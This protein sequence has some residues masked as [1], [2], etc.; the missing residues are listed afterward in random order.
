MIRRLPT[1]L[2]LWAEFAL[3]TVAVTAGSLVLGV[4]IRGTIL[5]ESGPGVSEG[6]VGLMKVQRSSPVPA[7]D[8]RLGPV[9][10][11]FRAPSAAPR[12]PAQH[13]E[14]MPASEPTLRFDG[15]PVR[16]VRT[17][18]MQVTAYSP[19]S[20]SCGR[21]ADGKTASGY[22]VWTNGMKLVA[23]DTRLLPFGTIV[24]IPG[25]NDGQPVQVLDRGGRIKGHRLDVLYP[26]HE[27]ARQW[28]A[29]Q[30]TVTVWEYAD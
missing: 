20:R 19:D 4:L 25:Y 28:G 13:I 3:L 11:N 23:A 8:G 14:P 5:R 26:T 7:G 24:T 15:R 22:S 1:N 17:L 27:I 29:R 18:S 30:S 9:V 12:Q 16:P 21:W 10:D 6:S 2:P